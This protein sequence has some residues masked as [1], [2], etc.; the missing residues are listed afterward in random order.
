MIADRWKTAALEGFIVLAGVLLAL[1]FDSWREGVE[2]QNLVKATEDQVA[3]E[4]QSNRD[5]LI[6]Y[7]EDFALRREKLDAWGENL[8]SGSGILD[9][10]EGFPGIPSTFMNKSAWNM[11]NNSQITEYL[12]HEFYDK[13]FSLYAYGDAMEARL[14][15]A[16]EVLF[17][18]Q[19]FDS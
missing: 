7:R 9:Q 15:I 16:L 13:A 2:F 10:L 14:D 17:D 4:I 3:E 5:R 11:V 12:N 8:D 19:G 1:F 18:I 6:T